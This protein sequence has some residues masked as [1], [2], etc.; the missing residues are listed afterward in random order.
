MHCIT[1][2]LSK[3]HCVPHEEIEEPPPPPPEP[4]PVPVPV[5]DPVPVPPEDSSGQSRAFDLVHSNTAR[6]KGR[7]D[8]RTAPLKNNI[9]AEGKSQKWGCSQIIGKEKRRME[10]IF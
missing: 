6:L 5:P 3:L 7:I 10:S 4:V 8:N 1:Q 2:A 9:L